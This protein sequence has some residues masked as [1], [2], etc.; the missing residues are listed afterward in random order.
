MGTPLHL[1]TFSLWSFS[2]IVYFATYTSYVFI[3]SKYL[4]RTFEYWWPKACTVGILILF[5]VLLVMLLCLTVKY[6][7]YW[8]FFGH[9]V[10]QA[11]LPLSGI[12]S[13]P[14]AV[15]AWSLNYWIAREVSAVGFWWIQFIG[16]RK[17]SSISGLLRVFLGF[18]GGSVVKKPAM[19]EMQVW[20]LGWEDPLEEGMATHSSILAWRIPW[21]EE[22]GGL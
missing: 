14:S 1:L 21:T 22:P 16:L 15:E 7:C 6:T 19:Q 18:S 9:I 11:E 3:I 17:H 13:R 8:V 4:N 5:L 2:K 10:Q 12:K 20:S